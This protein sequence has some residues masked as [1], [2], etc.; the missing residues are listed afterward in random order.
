MGRG[1]NR[2]RER[3]RAATGS[4]PARRGNKPHQFVFRGGQ[5]RQTRVTVT[6]RPVKR[7]SGQAYWRAQQ[8]DGVIEAPSTGCEA[9]G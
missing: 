8:G 1:T 6:P 4:H 3:S 5:G 7:R 2:R 9:G